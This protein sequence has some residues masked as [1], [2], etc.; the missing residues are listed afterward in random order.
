M[1]P[2]VFR[3]VGVTQS[4][5]R[6]AWPTIAYGGG[7]AVLWALGLVVRGWQGWAMLAA[8]LVAILAFRFWASRRVSVEVA[9]Q[10]LRYEGASPRRDW[11]VSL[12]R[13]KGTYFD[14]ALPGLPLVVVLDD[15]DE[16][17]C[18]EL[19]RSAARALQEH[20]RERGIPALA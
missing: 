18:L 6:L 9:E 10:T 15:G 17:A 7:F 3:G 19:S 4:A 14:R 11:E 1:Q 2:R 16:R 8:P 5:L 13:V 12:E 20:L